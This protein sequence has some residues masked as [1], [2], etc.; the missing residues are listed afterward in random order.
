MDKCW[1]IVQNLMQLNHNKLDYYLQGLRAME[2]I[3]SMVLAFMPPPQVDGSL[4][5]FQLSS[6]W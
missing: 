5:S 6:G 2:L 1:G 3:L 4:T